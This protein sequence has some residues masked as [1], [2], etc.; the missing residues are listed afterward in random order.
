MKR[1]EGD[2]DGYF[3]STQTFPSCYLF[4]GFEFTISRIPD[5]LLEIY[6]IWAS[7]C[8]F[9][10]VLELLI[11]FGLSS[12]RI[13]LHC[14]KIPGFEGEGR[15]KREVEYC[16]GWGGGGV[17]E[18]NLKE[19]NRVSQHKKIRK[20]WL[21]MIAVLCILRANWPIGRTE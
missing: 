5:V 3:N 20:I 10:I 11:M 17:H 13:Y 6:F 19:R 8:A 16:G 21:H 7:Y 12:N 18:R 9:F 1:G 14:S 15:L 2:T 4:S